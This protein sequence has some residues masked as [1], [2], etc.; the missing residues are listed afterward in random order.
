MQ[1]LNYFS[2]KKWDF[3]NDRVNAMHDKLTTQDRRKYFFDIKSIIWDTYFQ[4]YIQGIRVYLIKDPL[5]SL[6]V[7]RVKW[8]RYNFIFQA[9]KRLDLPDAIFFIFQDVLVS[10]G[11]QALDR[12]RFCQNRVGD[13]LDS[14]TLHRR[15]TIYN[16]KTKNIGYAGAYISSVWN[17]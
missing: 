13:S 9:W 7:A 16:L 8:Q 6:P 12:L 2:T 15:L 4:T 11:V 1:V 14:V 3:G 10:S 5:E 17:P